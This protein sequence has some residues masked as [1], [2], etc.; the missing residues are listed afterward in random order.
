MKLMQGHRGLDEA[1]R[2][3]MTLAQRGQ[4][5]PAERMLGKVLDVAPDQPDALQLLGM[6]ARRRQDHAAAI[7]LFRRSLAIRPAQPNVFNNLGNSLADTGR[8]GEAAEAY[9]T[10]LRLRPDYHEARINLAVSRIAAGMPAEARDLLLAMVDRLVGDARMWAVLGQALNALDQYDAAVR[11][12]ERSLVLRPGHVATRH[13]LAVALRRSGRSEAA[14]PILLDCVAADPGMADM[15][16]NLGHCLQDLGRIDDAAAAYAAAIAIRPAFRDAHDSLNRM[17]WRHGRHDSYLASYREALTASAF[18]PS[19]VDQGLLADYANR[20][21][22]SGQGAAAL[23]LLGPAIAQG[24]AQ[25]ELRYRYGQALWAQRDA[26]GAMAEYRAV[27]AIDA[28]FAP[29]ARELA[30][31]ALIIGQVDEA[32]ASIERLVAANPADQQALALQGIAWRLLGDERSSWLED[33]ALVSATL[34]I[35]TGGDVAGFNLRLDAAL[36]AVHG[37]AAAPLEQT[38]RGGTQSTDDLFDKHLPELDEVRAVIEAGVARYIAALPDDA[39]HPFLRRK[40]AGFAF[41]GSW[42]VRLRRAGYHENHIHP[43]G[44]ISAV[45]YVAVPPAVDD[46]MHGWLKFGETGLRLGERERVLRTVR[47]APGLLVLFPSYFYHGTIPFEDDRHRTT[48][49]FDII[50]CD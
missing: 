35:P 15:R 38:L 50:P 45:Y 48:I 6:I 13:N 12:F 44:W 33:P 41:S 4:L 31:A 10:A 7:P 20:L 46:D 24:G 49:A 19:P 47:P 42:S 27:L 11:A 30:R 1:L 34:L 9:R 2:E 18:D 26:A 8:H 36:D 43:E 37:A 25:V 16:H 5:D 40:A 28:D 21:L 29:A 3:A 17:L 22:L 14:L 32:L 23:A 39:A